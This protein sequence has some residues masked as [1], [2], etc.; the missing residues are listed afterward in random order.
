M[1]AWEKFESNHPD[2]IHREDVIVTER[3][4][5][6]CEIAVSADGYEILAAVGGDGTVGEVMTAIMSREASDVKLAIVPAGTGND[7]ARNAGIRSVEDAVAAV[8][9]GKPKAFDIMRVESQMDGRPV[10]N[11]S[12]L[13]GAVGF[14]SIPRIRPWMKRLL[15]AK[16]AYYLAT[17]IQ[18]LLYRTT[19][20][21]TKAEERSFRGK[22]WLV[23]VGNVESTAGGSMCL[24]PGARLDDGE[25]NISIFPHGSRIRMGLKLMPKIG[26]GEH[27][28][29]PGISYFPGRRIEIDSNPPAVVELDGDLRGMTPAKFAVCP[30]AIRVMTPE[31]KKEDV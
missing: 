26:S 4:G 27:V 15:G 30:G 10:V 12:F 16:G 18:L 22:A 31:T 23:L 7:I 20:M 14:S 3:P 1:K 5:H 6:A 19:E 11:Y 28:N 25:L 8:R 9:Y 2:K 29:V 21:T 13:A 17:L 24:A